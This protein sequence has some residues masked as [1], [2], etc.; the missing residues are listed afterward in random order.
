MVLGEPRYAHLLGHPLRLANAS[1]RGVHLDHGGHESTADA[2]VHSDAAHSVGLGVHHGVHDLIGERAQQLLHVD[3]AVVE[4][5][6]ASMSGVESDKF[7]ISIFVL[8]P[9]VVVIQILGRRP[10]F[11]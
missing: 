1:A 4:P 8:E 9:V 3:G 10:F 6:M 2:P 5:G 11:H 7:F